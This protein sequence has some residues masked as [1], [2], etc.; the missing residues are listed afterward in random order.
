MKYNYH[1]GK[2]ELYKNRYRNYQFVSK[3]LEKEFEMEDE[4]S[5]EQLYNKR[6][7]A[8]FLTMIFTLLGKYQN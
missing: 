6:K 8:E 4:F 2:D 7:L 1:F 3:I 5:S